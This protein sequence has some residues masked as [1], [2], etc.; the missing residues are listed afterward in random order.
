[1]TDNNIKQNIIDALES[2]EHPAIATTLRHL[3]ILRDHVVTDDLTVKL[4][5][6]L[7]FPNIPDNI[8]DYMVNSL[9]AAAQS[10]GGQLVEVKQGLMNDEERQSFLTIEQQNWRG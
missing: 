2:V 6:M 9:A 3:G 7:P 10:A 1:M 4:T 5:L 8:R